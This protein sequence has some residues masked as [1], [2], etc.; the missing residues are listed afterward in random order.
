MKTSKDQQ[1]TREVWDNVKTVN[2]FPFFSRSDNFPGGEDSPHINH[3]S[4][5]RPKGYGFWAFWS[6]NGYTLCPFRSEI[7]Y[8]FRGNYRS[9]WTYLSFQF[10]LNNKEVEICEFQMH[11]M[12][13][14]NLKKWWHN[15]SPDMDFR[16][17]VWKRVRKMTFL[18]LSLS[19]MGQRLDNRAAHP[20]PPPKKQFFFSLGHLRRNEGTRN[21]HNTERIDIKVLLYFKL[22]SVH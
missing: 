16:G 10:Q 7:G 2:V 1:K 3:I 13:C 9:V 5:Y 18:G 19:E 22:T 14:S 15:C 4:M 17:L 20:P 8:G 11:A 6:E 21:I 12:Q